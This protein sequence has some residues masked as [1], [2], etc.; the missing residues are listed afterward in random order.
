MHGNL[1]VHQAGVKDIVLAVNYR[2]EV[3]VNFMKKYEEQFGIRIVFS[4]ESEP[5]GTAGPLALAAE[6]LGKD[7]EPF[8]VLN[9]DVI[10]DFPFGE[11][12]A[13]HKAHGKE[14]TILVTKV[15]EPSKYGVVVNKPGTSAIDRFV[16]KPQVFVGNK[17]NVGKSTQLFRMME[18]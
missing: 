13:F 8:F 9:S 12:S 6:V 15:D 4:V 11:L 3:M 1:P 16:E 2:P 5:L 18:T 10:C 14:G 7:D 17:I